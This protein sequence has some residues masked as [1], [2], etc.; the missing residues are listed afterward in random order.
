[1][2]EI[3]RPLNADVEDGLT[4]DAAE[5]YFD[6]QKLNEAINAF[7]SYLQ[8]FPQGAHVLDAHNNLAEI[9]NTKKDWDRALQHYDYI[10]NNAPNQYAE[11]AMLVAG[12]ISFFEKKNYAAAERYYTQL[13]ELTTSQENKLEAMRA[14]CEANINF[15]NGLMLCKM[16]KT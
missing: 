16:Q 12:R 11:R 15:K 9:Y 7:N 3:G 5:K 10:V 2:R 1:M 8:K 13:K 6:D 4:Y 14:F